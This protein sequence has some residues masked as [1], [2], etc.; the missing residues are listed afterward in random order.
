MKTQYHTDHGPH[1]VEPRRSAN[2]ARCNGTIYTYTV[3]DRISIV[4]TYCHTCHTYNRPGFLLSTRHPIPT[5]ARDLSRI[6][7]A[8]HWQ[9]RPD[10]GWR[11]Y[12]AEASSRTEGAHQ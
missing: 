9:G 1:C 6:H 8:A 11:E 3:D 12:S 2:R 4:D 7:R 5:D 10:D